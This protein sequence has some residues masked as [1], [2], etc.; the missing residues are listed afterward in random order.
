MATPKLPFADVNFEEYGRVEVPSFSYKTKQT[1]QTGI[2]SL[3]IDAPYEQV[4]QAWVD[5]TWRA[6]GGFGKPIELKT[7]NP[8]G[9]GSIRTPGYG[10]LEMIFRVDKKE[11]LI[12]YSITRGLPLSS[13]YASVHFGE[14]DGGKRTLVSW[15]MRYTPRWYGVWLGAYIQ[16]Y[17][18]PQFLKNLKLYVETPSSAPY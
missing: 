6:G 15:I 10:L 12:E 13:H 3:E 17:L 5:Y 11:R 9:E 1:N 14:L 7:G 4:M 16:Y 2:V 8:D 18:F